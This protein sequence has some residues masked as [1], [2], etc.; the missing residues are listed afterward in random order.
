MRS[1]SYALPVTDEGHFHLSE[2][3]EKTYGFVKVE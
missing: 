3:G 1:D 2:K